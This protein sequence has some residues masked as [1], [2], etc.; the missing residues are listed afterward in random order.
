MRGIDCNPAFQ[1]W[2][3]NEPIVSKLVSRIGHM[4]HWMAAETVVKLVMGFLEAV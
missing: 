1:D 3:S 2:C 4:L